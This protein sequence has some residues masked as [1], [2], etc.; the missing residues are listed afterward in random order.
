MDLE[1]KVKK[2]AETVHQFLADELCDVPE[3]VVL[4]YDVVNIKPG[5][6]I[7]YIIT[8]KTKES[9]DFESVT[10]VISIR[11]E[12]NISQFL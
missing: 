11:L 3:I 12:N 6:R 10:I 7:E 1:E 2:V 5:G 9:D 8:Y 4:D